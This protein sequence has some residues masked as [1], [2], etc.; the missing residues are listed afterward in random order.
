M[1]DNRLETIPTSMAVLT[2]MTRLDLSNNRCV[3]MYIH[4]YVGDSHIYSYIHI[5]I[6]TCI[7]LETI[8]TSMA[9]DEAEFE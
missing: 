6:Y 2:S 9:D 7:C 8:P 4:V 1:P 3:C 5:H